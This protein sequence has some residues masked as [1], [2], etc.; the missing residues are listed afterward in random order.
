MDHAALEVDRHA[1][2]ARANRRG[3][4]SM[5][6]AMGCFIINDALIKYVSQTLPLAQVVFIRSALASLL[7]LAVMK[8]MGEVPRIRES[9]R[10]W[11]ALR[12]VLDAIA[13]M[14]FLLSLLHLPLATATAINMASPLFIT[15][16]AAFFIGERIGAPRWLAVGVGFVGVLLII[17]PQ[18]DGF[19]AYAWVCLAAT[20]LIAVRDLI[21]RRVNGSIPS[22]V[23]TFSNTAAVMLLA[24]VWSLA[25]GWRPISGSGIG[26]LSIAAMFLA[27]AYYLIVG[28]TR[29]GD[30]SLIVPF[31]YTAILFAAVAGFFIWGDTPNALAWGGM[32]LLISSGIYVLHTSGRQ[33]ANAALDRA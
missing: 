18:A 15:A 32:G 10:G 28:S 16:L 9:T 11:V 14:L 22:I 27:T 8:A 5:I 30:L 23:I 26:L 17:Q 29:D 20:F 3:I 19:D 12:A 1:L 31:R 4:V 25:E 24:G 2:A 6:G 7:V 33:R 21:T 13:T